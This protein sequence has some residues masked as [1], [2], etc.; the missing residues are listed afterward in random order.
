MKWIEDRD[1][2]L[3]Q[4]SHTAHHIDSHD[5]FWWPQWGKKWRREQYS[6]DAT[7]ALAAIFLSL[8]GPYMMFTGGEEGIEGRLEEILQFR[9]S[10]PDAWKSRGQ[11]DTNAD[12]SG[13][14]IIVKRHSQSGSIVS[15]VNSSPNLVVDVPRQYRDL[16]VQIKN[17][18]NGQ[19]LEPLGYLFGH[20]K[21]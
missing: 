9:N 7:E 17:R 3:P 12:G 6:I 1:E 19:K 20:W 11:F 8:D 14:L 21:P 15:I 5:T 13:K 10:N 16:K 2:F 4:G 18:F